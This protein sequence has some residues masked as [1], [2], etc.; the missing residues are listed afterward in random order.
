MNIGKGI[1]R[2]L[3]KR[4]ETQKS[5]AS[6]IEIS[7]TSLSQI[8]QDRTQPRK[9]TIEKIANALQV[10]PEVLILLS[11]EKKDL[12]EEKGNLYDLLWPSLEANLFQL[13]SK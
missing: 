3:K 5:L 9:E 10:K 8:I 11:L 1:K 6:K 13:L 12:P 2:V 7:E 4:N